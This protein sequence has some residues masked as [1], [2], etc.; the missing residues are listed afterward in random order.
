MI[1]GFRR[2]LQGIWDR[3]NAPYCPEDP[4]K[5]PTKGVMFE[6]L[7]VGVLDGLARGMWIWKDAHGQTD[8]LHSSAGRNSQPRFV[9]F[10]TDAL[11]GGGGGVSISLE[12]WC[13]PPG[14]IYDEGGAPECGSSDP[15][16]CLVSGS[17]DWSRQDQ[18]F[19][20]RPDIPYKGVLFAPIH[21]TKYTGNIVGPKAGCVAK[22]SN[23][24]TDSHGQDDHLSPIWP[25][26]DGDATGCGPTTW[27]LTNFY[28]TTEI[29]PPPNPNNRI[30][31]KLI[32]ERL[33]VR[34]IP[35]SK[36]IGGWTISKRCCEC[37]DR[38]SGGAC[39]TVPGCGIGEWPGSEAYVTECCCTSTS[40]CS[41]TVSIA[42]DIS[43]T[44]IYDDGQTKIKCT[45]PTYYCHYAF[46]QCC[47][48]G[49][50]D[51]HDP[52]DTDLCKAGGSIWPCDCEYEYDWDDCHVTI[53][54]DP[55]PP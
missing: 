4:K 35:G 11:C 38:G 5:K 27:M 34:M 39:C 40:C 28:I 9:F 2:V 37:C 29:C 50:C 7:V 10:A 31:Y 14:T 49:G 23:I 53:E 3:Q 32:K 25:E 24:F 19:K 43:G 55:G 22:I 54:T 13:V 8:H 30:K 16:E 51:V 52:P 42:C 48:S 18:P 15:I 46:L 20:R 6:S 44:V 1:D 21:L 45:A 36:L 33:R 12:A 47:G 26:S 41:P 17:D